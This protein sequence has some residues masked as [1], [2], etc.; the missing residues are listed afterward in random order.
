[1]QIKAQD[2]VFSHFFLNTIAMN[3]ANTG[4]AND[5]R[6]CLH[7]RN[8]WPALGN[9]FITY[10]G[11]YDQFYDKIHSGLGLNFTRD[12][13]ASGTITSTN[14]DFMYSYRFKVM[15]NLTV[16]TGLQ[17]SLQSYGTNFRQ[18]NSA[19]NN[20]LLTSTSAINPDFGAGIL[21]ISRFSEIG[22]SIYHLNSGF[23][24]LSNNFVSTPFLF[25]FY[26]SRDFKLTNDRINSN[27][28]LTAS[29][30]IMAVSQG[31]STFVDIGTNFEKDNLSVGIWLRNNL[32]I[33]LNSIIFSAGIS[34][35][36]INFYY[37]YDYQV[38]S[39]NNYQPFTGAHEITI[40]KFL[41]KNPKS[42]RFAP[43]KCPDNIP[44]VQ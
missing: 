41:R 8:Q 28:G 35:A 12:N 11:S 30:A 33:Q 39:L 2:Q 26:Y 6:L 38:P 25:S 19:T 32:P 22:F 40:I 31:L 16:Q 37:S 23:I 4:S 15:R 9:A 36:N 18:F 1:M 42:K 21:G 7:Y 27:G 14:V 24:K 17:A 43:I 29:P 3:P 34:L 20:E 13:M 5:P 44:N 10:Q